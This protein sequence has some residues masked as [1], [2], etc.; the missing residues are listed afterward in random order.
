MAADDESRPNQN[1][2]DDF[3]AVVLDEEDDLEIVAEGQFLT[4]S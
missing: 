4:G 3:E 2:P 1:E